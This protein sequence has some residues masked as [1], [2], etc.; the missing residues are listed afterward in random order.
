L[1]KANAA[2]QRSFGFKPFQVGWVRRVLIDV[3]HPWYRIS[4]RLKSFP[5]EAL[6]AG[7]L[8]LCREQKIDRLASRV[9]RTVEIPIF[10]LNLY[11]G[12]VHAIALVCGFRCGR[13]RLSNSGAYAWTHRQNAA[14]IDGQAALGQNLGNV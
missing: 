10:A 4:R 12:L 9:H 8:T 14:G 6:C 2:R 1:A 5:K 7:G 13:Q 11:I 3:H